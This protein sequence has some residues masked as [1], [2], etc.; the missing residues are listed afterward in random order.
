[1]TRWAKCRGFVLKSKRADEMGGWGDG[2]LTDKRCCVSL[3]PVAAV[4]TQYNKFNPHKQELW[5]QQI[6]FPVAEKV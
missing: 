3:Q 4:A 5:E 2:Q 1:M 6:R